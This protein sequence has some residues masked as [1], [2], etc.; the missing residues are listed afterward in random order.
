MRPPGQVFAGEFGSESAEGG[1]DALARLDGTSRR[2]DLPAFALDA[3]NAHRRQSLAE[4]TLGDAVFVAPDGNYL[5][6]SNMRQRSF[7]KI[8]AR[9]DVPEIR[10]HDLRHTCATMLL[11]AGENIKVVSER[12]GHSSV[13]MTLEVYAHVLP[14][15]QK[16]AADTM[17]KLLG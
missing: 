9:A 16:Q 3:L 7:G 6:P 13:K 10:F 4:G 12:L 11:A 17:Q 2:V 8:L 5:Q 1:N 14:G 15:M